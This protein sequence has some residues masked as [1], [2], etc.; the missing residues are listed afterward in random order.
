MICA[1][2]Q[3][4]TF[5]WLG[6][7]AKIIQ[8]DVF[9]IL[10][11]VQFK[12][13]EWQ[14]R[15][16]IK[17]VAGMQWLTVPVIHKFGQSINEVQINSQSN[18][19]HKH[20]QAIK[21]NY[22]KSQYYHVFMPDI[23]QLYDRDWQSLA[24]FNLA[25]IKWVLEKLAIKT[26]LVVASEIDGLKKNADIGPDD[27][28]ILITKMMQADTYLSGAGGHNYLKTDLF[29][30]NK[31]KL[32]FQN[33]EHPEYQQ[34]HGNFISHLSVLDLLFNEGPNARSLIEGGIR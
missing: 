30:K 18:W 17:T 11:N 25:G 10:D 8:A 33:F 23:E 34:L 21:T 28:L 27:R 5:P 7:I 29:L 22:G 20:I 16:R 4:Q 12:K 26:P 13:N 31:L 1:I 6:Y 24:E 3:P 2:H 9:I 32:I 14:N 15:N 19:Q